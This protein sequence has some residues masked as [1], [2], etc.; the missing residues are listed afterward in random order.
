MIKNKF[1]NITKIAQPS[2]SVVIPTKN[3]ASTIPTMLDSLIK[4]DYKNFNVIV[5][6]GGSNDG[7][8]EVIDSYKNKLKIIL[9][10]QNGGLV[11]QVNKA[12]ELTDADIFIRTDDDAEYSSRTISEIVKTFKVSDD[13][14]GV[15]GPT[16]TPDKSTRDLFLFQQKFK[17]NNLFW[18]IIGKIY[19]GYIFD[20]RIEKI[21]EI[22]KSGVAT[23][24]ANNTETL[25]LKKNIEMVQ[26]ECITYAIR[27]DLLREINGFD[28][29][30]ATVGDC[31][32]IDASF[33]LRD[34]GFKIMLNPKAY[35][36]HHTSK[37][38][39][40]SARSGSFWRMVNFINFYFRHIKP[41]TFSKAFHFSAY[42]IFQ[43][44]YYS[45]MFFNQGKLSFL[46]SYPATIYAI[47]INIFKKESWK[48]GL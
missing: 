41:N 18:R 5:V 16:I 20:G 42:I 13:I 43:N 46:G 21:G 6:D 39:V 24:G 38:G 17:K 28:E 15:S 31:H 1:K 47:I 36:I 19:F 10:T 4:Q 33:R 25:K 3:R 40:F 14:G 11:R 22:T 29:I 48:G 23:L 37:E 34:L 7:T 2:V 45:Y 35:A 44:L 30:F 12:I 27:T 32:E 26:H 9:Y 8:I